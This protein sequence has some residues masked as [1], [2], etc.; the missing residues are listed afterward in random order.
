MKSMLILLILGEMAKA[1]IPVAYLDWEWNAARHLARKRRLFGPE[2]LDALFYLRCRNSLAVEQDHIRRFCEER[3]IAFIGL[4]SIGAACDGKLADDDVA[5]AYN[6]ALDDLPPSLAAAH[7]PK[8][9]MEPGADPKAFG[10]AFFH[11]YAPITWG[12]K[13][14]VGVD[15]DLV[16]I[17]LVPSKQNDGARAQPSSRVSVF[18]GP[19]SR[20]ARRSRERRWPLRAPL[21][22][23]SY[24]SPVEVRANDHRRHRGTSER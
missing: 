9:T 2:R 20:A 19:N 11:T 12:V 15:D 13:K 14:Q 10:S 23:A 5:R 4:D 24:V 18:R 6:R 8:G 7:V 22:R 16:T 21:D 17:M 3:A 1:G